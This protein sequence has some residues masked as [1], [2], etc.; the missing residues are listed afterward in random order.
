MA[1][2]AKLPRYILNL[3]QIRLIE[4]EPNPPIVVITWASGEEDTMLKGAD[5]LALMD[6]LE[7][8]RDL[9]DVS[10]PLPLEELPA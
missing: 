3:N 7:Q 8:S 5:A 10:A 4:F 2:F 9:I 1:I 6:A